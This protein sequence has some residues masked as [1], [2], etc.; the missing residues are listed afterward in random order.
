MVDAW[1]LKSGGINLHSQVCIAYFSKGRISALDLE[2]K[3]PAKNF[4]ILVL[5]YMY[6]IPDSE[7][8]WA[9]QPRLP[10]PSPSGQTTGFDRDCYRIWPGPGR[11]SPD[12]PLKVICSYHGPTLGRPGRGPAGNRQGWP[13]PGRIPWCPELPG[14]IPPGIRAGSLSGMCIAV[15]RM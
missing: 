11:A 4:H 10:G 6:P 5:R 14:R 9:G 8:I 2:V 7:P 1:D 3:G 15:F 12:C 13:L